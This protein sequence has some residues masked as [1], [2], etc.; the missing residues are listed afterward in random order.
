MDKFEFEEKRISIIL[1]T[2]RPNSFTS[3]AIRPILDE[4]GCRNIKVDIIDPSKLKL[5]FPGI[6]GDN[7][8]EKNIKLTR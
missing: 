4:L 6:D 5:F 2:S 7:T 1:G 8:D 3:K